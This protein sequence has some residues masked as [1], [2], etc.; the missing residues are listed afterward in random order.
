MSFHDGFCPTVK[1]RMTNR[2]NRVIIA[3][4]T[5]NT[6]EQLERA[7]LALFVFLLY[8]SYP[9]LC[10]RA[11]LWVRISFPDFSEGIRR[12]HLRAND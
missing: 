4:S 8:R 7:V 9:D 10:E 11:M 3:T 5:K 2:Y 12:S 6:G 1:P